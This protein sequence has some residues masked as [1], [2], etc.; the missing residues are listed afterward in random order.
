M[1]TI[2][3]IM[4][5]RGRRRVFDWHRAANR[6]HETRPASAGAGL[7]NDYEWTFGEIF[8]GE[9]ADESST[10]VFLASDWATPM[11]VMTLPDGSEV[12]E[13][14]W[15]YQDDAPG[16]NE[17]TFWPKSAWDILRGTATYHPAMLS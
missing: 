12:E 14:C 2:D 7:L 11:L 1:R 10:Y 8:D 6:I 13:E 16:W 4:Q 5:P 15:I 9:P 17:K 3:A